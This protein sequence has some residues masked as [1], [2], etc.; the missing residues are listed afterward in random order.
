MAVA[1]PVGIRG[2]IHVPLLGRELNTL[3]ITAVANDGVHDVTAPILLWNGSDTQA[4][5]Q[6]QQ[7]QQEQL[8]QDVQ[9]L[10]EAPHVD[11]V[12]DVVMLDTTAVE[13]ELTLTEEMPC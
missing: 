4:I 9:W 8:E 3:T 2:K 11:R 7:Q 13:L 1:V 10:R 6:Q 12:R 5:I